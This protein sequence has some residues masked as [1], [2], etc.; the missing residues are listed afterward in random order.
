MSPFTSRPLVLISPAREEVLEIDWLNLT[1]LGPEGLAAIAAGFGQTE[2]SACDRFLDSPAVVFTYLISSVVKNKQMWQ[3]RG[4]RLSFGAGFENSASETL[5]NTPR[6]AAYQKLIEVD[7]DGF[8]QSRFEGIVLSV[9][10]CLRQTTAICPSGYPAVLLR[11][12]RKP[13]RR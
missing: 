10:R 5:P 9:Q 8:L 11:A 4:C 3:R 12:I 6:S 13:P 7:T 1:A 2:R